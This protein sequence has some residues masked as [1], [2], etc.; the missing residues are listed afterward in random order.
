M[1]GAGI[2]TFVAGSLLV[3]LSWAV[4]GIELPEAYRSLTGVL[5]EPLALLMVALAWRF[6]RSRLAIAA[7]LIALANVLVRGPLDLSAG[8]FGSPG[9][10]AL[11][12]LFPINLAVIVLSRDHPLPR[13]RPLIHLAAV[14]LQPW[15]VAASLQLGGRIQWPGGLA[16]G[17]MLLISAPQAALLAALI[18]GVFAA[19]AFAARRGTFEVA[20]PWVLAAGALALIGDGD[21]HRATVMFAG[22]QLVLLFALVEDSY[23]LAYH[24]QLTGLA[25]RRALDE[26]M[27]LLEGD[28]TI[29]MADID[30]FKRFN[31][32]Y[33]HEVGDQALR[34]VADQIERVQLEQ[35][36][37]V[38]EE[39]G[40]SVRS[41]KRPRKKPE[42]PVK[43][44]TPVE[45]VTLT[46]S[47][48]AAGPSLQN[49]DPESVL[50]AADAALYRAKR[51]GR[52]RLVV[53]GVRAKPRSTHR[54][55][56]SRVKAKG[57]K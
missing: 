40:F 18:A 6:R 52:N 26:S 54:R 49:P 1:T 27:K 50:R 53:E 31:D 39:R 13:G 42:Q 4:A 30:H 37:A 17:W 35:L 38:V 3:L 16:P 21:V 10:A 12:L 57:L 44:S 36:R 25:G 33:G 46:I 14:L 41:P 5:A 22:A 29:A 20:V 55:S 56:N 2:F 51:R 23:R 19:L 7:V 45:Q 43:S 34:M 9:H 24:D 32:R 11:A 8:G 48:G 28:Y 15:L 47:V